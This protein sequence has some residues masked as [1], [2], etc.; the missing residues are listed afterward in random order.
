M[1]AKKP[2][3]IVSGQPQQLQL[4]DDIGGP[5]GYSWAYLFGGF[6]GGP[7]S[8]GQVFLDDGLSTPSFA[9]SNLFIHKSDKNGIDLTAT[10]AQMQKG[11]LIRVY[12]VGDTS[13]FLEGRL[14]TITDSGTYYSIGL[15]P[16]VN[17]AFTIPTVGDVL[18][19][20]WLPLRD[21]IFSA[22]T[23]TAFAV[24]VPVY[25]AGAN[26]VDAAQANSFT[27]SSVVGLSLDASPAPGNTVRVRTSGFME[28]TTGQWDAIAGTSGGLAPGTEY[29]LSQSS[30]G[31]LVGST[32]AIA[33]RVRIGVA[34]SSTVMI[35]QIG[36]PVAVNTICKVRATVSGGVVTTVG[37]V[38][39][40]DPT[41][42]TRNA[43]G[44]FTF[45][46]GGTFPDTGFVALLAVGEDGLGNLLQVNEVARTT[47]TVQYN[48]ALAG[49]LTDPV[50]LDFLVIGP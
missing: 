46:V 37:I 39:N 27:T 49:V 18:G 10:L 16:I 3:V 50:S 7:P 28:L 31:Q 38:G 42:I 13:R 44:D 17:S 14:A 21:P 6:G 23:A 2:M 30:A 1:A 45:T 26:T 48:V 15:V 47:S 29:F 41:P 4:G 5:S 33:L 34:L 22:T 19:V 11:D 20:S 43:A 35:L 32:F 40:M 36:E 9:D 25:M 24:G 8:A 12:S